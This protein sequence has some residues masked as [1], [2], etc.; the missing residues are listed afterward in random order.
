MPTEDPVVDVTIDSFS[1]GGA[2]VPGQ[3]V[4]ITGRIT[5]TSTAT[6]NEPQA[7]SCIEPKRMTT[8]AELA[9]IDIEADEPVKDRNKCEG[10]TNADST[11]W[12]QVAPS[13]APK[14]SVP[15]KL[16]VPWDEWEISDEPGVYTVGVRFRGNIT[17]ILV[18]G[19]IVT[20]PQLHAAHALEESLV[21]VALPNEH[22]N[23]AGGSSGS[24]L[25]SG[26]PPPVACR[27][28]RSAPRHRPRK[29][30]GGR[31]GR[32]LLI[33]RARR[34]HH[35]RAG[36]AGSG[37]S[38]SQSGHSSPIPP[39]DAFPGPGERTSADRH[40]SGARESAATAYATPGAM[41]SKRL[42]QGSRLLHRR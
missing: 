13:L 28:R 23:R 3:A 17:D 4:T 12:Q 27:S 2:G 33:G 22:P 42:A 39:D 19:E 8:R 21:V 36:P 10:L 31:P 30:T 18:L 26:P 15:F 7:L 14:A 25:P 37:S 41:V 16:V 20:G 6:F 40:R 32:L 29:P 35:W 9:S 1:P 38:R 5:N 34:G 11:T 24:P